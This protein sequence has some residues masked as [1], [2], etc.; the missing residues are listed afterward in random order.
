MDLLDLPQARH[1]A[2]GLRQAL[3][4]PGHGPGRTGLHRRLLTA[5]K[6]AT[7]A[8]VAAVALGLGTAVL[9]VGEAWLLA[10]A[11]A[12]AFLGGADIRALAPTLSALALV[13]A[14]RA[15]ISWI[16]EVVARRISGAV[17]ADLR[18]RVLAA[19]V[20]L[21]PRL[22]AEHS[23]AAV[24]L[25]ATRGLDALDGY[26]GRYLPQV[27]LAAI[28]PVAVVGCLFAVDVIAALTVALTVPL[29]PVFTVLIGK[30]AAARRDRRWAALGRLA[31]RFADTVAGLPTLRAYGR[32]DAQVAILRRTTDAYRSATMDT[33]RVAFLSALALELLA[34]ISVALVA[35]GVGLRLVNGSLALET[36]L[37][38]LVLAP[39]A[40]LPLRRL[41]A[42]FHASEEGVAAAG[43]AFAL[44]DAAEAAASR[45]AAELRAPPE[46][47]TTLAVERVGVVQP[48]RE[49]MAPAGVSLEIRPGEVVALTGPSGAGKSTLLAAI[50][51]F[52]QPSNGRIVV[53]GAVGG[54]G[55]TRG[56]AEHGDPADP[57]ALDLAV[58]DAE[59]WRRQ[60][61]WVPQLPTLVPGTVA[62]NVRLGA[63]EATDPQVAAAL[64]A[65]GLDDMDPAREVGERGR[66]LSGGERRRIGVARALVR[67]AP[68]LLLDEPTA[69]L[70]SAAEALVIAA[71]RA[72][73]DRGA[74]VLL[75]AHRPGAVA[76]ADH[77]V[78]VRWAAIESA[79]ETGASH[80]SVVDGP[81]GA[82][83]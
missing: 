34:T 53:R 39:E 55:E 4:P 32:A 79:G 11:I 38:A 13:L 83:A 16:A 52:V 54:A 82:M 68:L 64:A 44:L 75:V 9:A 46:R 80:R 40:Y 28:V 81:A 33:L 72:E 48:G 21:G 25:L 7:A 78:E 15:G 57:A 36:G 8:F 69:G 47:F 6:T 35:V 67:R 20:A 51:R 42:E 22:A 19:A 63:P 18:R 59:A 31:T 26:Y 17:K 77:V 10:H 24:A 49:T 56:P 12:A 29:I 27:A 60:I 66:G 23:T 70:D 61:A 74:A 5:G 30:A 43:S 41:G 62:E 58:I 3:T 37:F 50:L 45:E 1:G 65:V 14:A 71:I 2:A 76:G 73:A